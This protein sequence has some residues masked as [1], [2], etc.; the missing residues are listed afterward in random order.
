MVMLGLKQMIGDSDWN[1]SGTLSYQVEL[2][3]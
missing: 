3:Q 2:W 1:F